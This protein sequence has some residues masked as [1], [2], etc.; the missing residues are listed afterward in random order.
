MLPPKFRTVKQPK[1]SK[2]CAA[3]M[4]AMVTGH[5]L[6]VVE[7]AMRKTPLPDGT[8]Y[9]M[10][11]ECLAYLGRHAIH[12]GLT[13]QPTINGRPLV[14]PSISE[15]AIDIK[16]S[17]V[18]RP[19]M[20]VVR[21]KLYRNAEHFVLWDGQ[22]VRDS[23]GPDEVNQLHEYEIIEIMPL[24]YYDDTHESDPVEL[25]KIEDDCHGIR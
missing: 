9:Y 14:I 12:T 24:T 19:C 5:E 1:G 23:S 10:T 11:N 15:A 13:F 2:I 8:Y 18:G 20:L 22:F 3:C 21:S 4:V 25:I 16:W 7:A 17:M 6:D